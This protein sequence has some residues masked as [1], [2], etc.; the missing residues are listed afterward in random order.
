MIIHDSVKH[1]MG[2]DY[3]DE[4]DD[5]HVE[6]GTLKAEYDQLAKKL[7][8]VTESLDSFLRDDIEADDEIRNLARPILGE[9][10]DGDSF[11]V[12]GVVDIVEKLITLLPRGEQAR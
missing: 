10:V 5:I 4:N 12:P 7:Q 1:V 3:T 11:G 6:R 2:N 9:W 8:D